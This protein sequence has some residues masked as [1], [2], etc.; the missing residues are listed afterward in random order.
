MKT[1]FELN[2]SSDGQP[3]IRFKHHD[4]SNSLE[5]KILK[6][7]IDGIKKNGAIIENPSGFLETGTDNSYEIYEIKIDK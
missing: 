3:C 4:R 5:Q 2:I 1:E 6:I 7:L